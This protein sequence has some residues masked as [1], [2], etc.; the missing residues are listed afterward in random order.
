MDLVC[1]N[2]REPWDMETVLHESPERFERHGGA[3]HSC[4]S[5]KGKSV[6]LSEEEEFKSMATSALADVLGDDIDGLAASLEDFNLL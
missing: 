6:E 4:P 3:I 5:C 2:C 1:L